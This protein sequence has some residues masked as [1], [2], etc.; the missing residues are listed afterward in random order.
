MRNRRSLSQAGQPPQAAARR[1]GG[2]TGDDDEQGDGNHAQDVHLARNLAQ[3][4]GAQRVSVAQVLW[5]YRS[6][7]RS[8]VR[9]TRCSVSQPRRGERAVYGRSAAEEGARLRGERGRRGSQRRDGGERRG[10]LRH[11][12]A[13]ELDG[14]AG[15]GSGG[16]SL[17]RLHQGSDW[18]SLS[19]CLSRATGAAPTTQA[20]IAPPALPPAAASSRRARAAARPASR[21]KEPYLDGR[22]ARAA[23]ALRRQS[24]RWQAE[25][26]A[27]H[28]DQAR[29]G[30][31]NG[32]TMALL[33]Y[34]A[35]Y[36][37]R[38]H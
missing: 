7:L 27:R 25:S 16:G 9:P 28:R 34:G 13:V 23:H 24:E 8:R 18:Y 12:G 2:R 1:F 20:S 10:R 32:V 22:A 38:R 37:M 33:K 11:R 17:R 6:P 30:A 29:K 3:L 21:K 36:E 19:R 26:D 15:G 31:E 4:L 14:A 5:L 35:N